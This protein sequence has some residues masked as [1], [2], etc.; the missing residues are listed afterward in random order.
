MCSA[1]ACVAPT[2]PAITKKVRPLQAVVGAVH[3]QVINVTGH[4]ARGQSDC[5]IPFGDAWLRH[6]SYHVRA[7]YVVLLC[8]RHVFLYYSCLLCWL[9]VNVRTFSI[10]SLTQLCGVYNIRVK[11]ACSLM[12]FH[13][14]L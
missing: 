13:A 14:L 7:R 9:R 6:P 4:T 1:V 12:H 11:I 8:L 10:S 5:L 3:N 2:S